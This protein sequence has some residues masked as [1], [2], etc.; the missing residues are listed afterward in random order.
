M[1]GY[2]V[3]ADTEIDEDIH[4]C[5]ILHWHVGTKIYR[6]SREL[7]AYAETC[8]AFSQYYRQDYQHTAGSMDTY[9]RDALKLYTGIPYKPRNCTTTSARRFYAWYR[10]FKPKNTAVV[11]SAEEGSRG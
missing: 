7:L 3:T 4:E 11:V 8:A 2:A 5:I 6:F 10:L 1:Q 9:Y